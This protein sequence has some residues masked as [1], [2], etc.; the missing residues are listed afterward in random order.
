[1]TRASA[2][3]VGGYKLRVTPWH[4]KRHIALVGPA[5]LR[6]SPSTAEIQRCL[7]ALAQRGVGLAFTPALSPFEAEPFLQAGFELHEELHLLARH[8]GD[9]VPRPRHKL[10]AGRSWDR[11]RV[12]EIDALAFE[13]FWQFDK[14][15][16]REARQATPSH[17]FR[18]AVDQ[19]KV[20]GYA[21]TG[22]AGRRGYLQRLAV[23][24]AH[25]G[26]GIGTSLI[27][28]CFRWLERHSADLVMVNTQ[29]TNQRALGLYQHLGF[30]RQ[31]EGLLVLRWAGTD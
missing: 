19:R 24:P 20:I 21:V 23:D 3:T 29:Q 6:R 10:R 13:S 14:V 15:S 25:A 22:R 26:R 9:G 28:D 30:V 8:L 16:L 7:D 12:L 1:M 11:S 5:R 2:A 17:R 18:V 27:N 31:R 4:G